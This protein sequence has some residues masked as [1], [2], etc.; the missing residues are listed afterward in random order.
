MTPARLTPVARFGRDERGAALLEFS[1]MLLLLLILIFGIVDFGRAI[2]TANALSLAARE[3]ARYAAV[4]S[5]PTAA[6][7]QDTVIAHMSPFAGTL[8][9]SNI[10]V[11]FNYG[12]SGSPPPLQS[13][14]VSVAYPFTWLTPIRALLGLSSTRAIHT[15]AQ[16]RYELGG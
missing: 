16:Y 5:T 8:S 9:R 1:F 11:T 15:S 10:T 13:T 2:Y 4:S 14:T 6:D 3:G 7:I 12:S